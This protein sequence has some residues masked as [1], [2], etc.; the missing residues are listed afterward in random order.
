MNK[1][2]NVAPPKAELLPRDVALLK[3][4]ERIRLLDF[5]IQPDQCVFLTNE[6]ITEILCNQA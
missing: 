2:V 6:E 3:E 4:L 5:T 1:K